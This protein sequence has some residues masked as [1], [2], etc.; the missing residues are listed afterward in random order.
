M[1]ST[2]TQYTV[3]VPLNP[4]SL[5]TT[6]KVV[7]WDSSEGKFN[8]ASGLNGS[9]IPY[10]YTGNTDTSTG[11]FTLNNSTPSS[12]TELE[13]NFT[14][15]DSVNYKEVLTACT[16]GTVYINSRSEADDNLVIKFSSVT[17]NSSTVIYNIS[18]VNGGLSSTMVNGDYCLTVVCDGVDGLTCY[19]YD[20]V[21]A[22]S[23]TTIS[24]NSCSCDNRETTTTLLPII[25][26][27]NSSSYNG[28]YGYPVEQPVN[29]G[30]EIGTVS[31][32]FNAISIPDR[33][34]VYYNNSV[35]IDTGY[36]G[37]SSYSYDGNARTSFT[38]SLEGLTDPITG[39][40]YP[41]SDPSNDVDGYPIVT[42]PGTVTD[43]FNKNISSV[44]YG[45]IKVYGPMSSTGWS[46]DIGCP[47]GDGAPVGES[48]YSVSICA[49]DTPTIIEGDTGITINC[50]GMCMGSSTSDS[51][52]TTSDNCTKW[53]YNTGTTATGISTGQIRFNNSNI[54]GAT[55]I[56]IHKDSG[57]GSNNWY[58]YFKKLVE[59]LCCTLKIRIPNGEHN[60]LIY[61]FDDENSTLE[62]DY[63][64]FVVS[65]IW[66][67]PLL[68][69][70]D[71][72]TL[73]NNDELCIEFDLFECVK[74]QKTVD[75]D[76]NT[77]GN[78]NI[79]SIPTSSG[80]TFEYTY[81][82]Q[83][84]TTRGFRAGK[85][86]AAVNESGTVTVFSDTSTVDGTDTT[87]DIE[88]STVISG[89]NLILRA[90][91]T[92]STTWNVK[93]KVEVLF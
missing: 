25:D 5:P 47:K 79:I 36:R 14:A 19:E 86:L 62:N 49:T 11:H 28:G 56:Y 31:I 12:A 38:N 20:I 30:T 52:G 46:M 71:F 35:K 45:I 21:P 37:G 65:N 61:D 32:D 39:N 3:K 72:I 9:C 57:S 48:N 22:D 68:N 89:S 15:T 13:V 83:E 77:N 69:D 80:S 44:T 88:F 2:Q 43:T 40:I 63:L 70:S 66:G 78:H 85:V 93:A 18:S 67:A 75:V 90:I 7:I 87:E 1:S 64:K 4:L 26:C 53:F 16:I 10:E 74:Y 27:G 50:V 73:F 58:G 34:I 91:T 33:F 8:L 6:D 92:N 17:I 41:F 29:F 23:A 42:S 55:E 81:F 51:T 59:S 82:V 76:V 54:T 84:G 24:Y 60:Y